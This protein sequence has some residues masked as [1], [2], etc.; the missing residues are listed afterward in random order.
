MVSYVF[1]EP[2]YV[3]QLREPNSRALANFID[4]KVVN[5]LVDKFQL[6]TGQEAVEE[7]L[8]NLSPEALSSDS[9]EKQRNELSNLRN[10]LARVVEGENVL[11][12]Y[13]DIS[14]QLGFDFST[15]Q[16]VVDRVATEEMLTDMASAIAQHPHKWIEERV[17]A[18]RQ[19]YLRFKIKDSVCALPESQAHIL[20]LANADSVGHLDLENLQR[21]KGSWAYYCQITYSKWLECFLSEN[22]GIQDDTFQDYQHY[23]SLNVAPIPSLSSSSAG[24]C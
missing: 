10:A 2:V 11:T 14:E 12:V 22:V 7:Y 6:P 20:V 21:N 5:F 16:N 1:D 8:L 9:I 23:S 24:G 4:D 13:E 17:D 19:S 3:E 18:F 15:W